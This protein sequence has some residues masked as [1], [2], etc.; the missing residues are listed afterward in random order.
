[1]DS[2]NLQTLQDKE[3]EN[4]FAELKRLT[5]ENQNQNG[6]LSYLILHR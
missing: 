5:A 4:E 2:K 6:R 1:M 3:I